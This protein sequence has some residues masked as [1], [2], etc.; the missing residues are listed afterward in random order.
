SWDRASRHFA[1]V[2]GLPGSADLMDQLAVTDDP[3]LLTVILSGGA[4]SEPVPMPENAAAR[5]R[6]TGLS[7][8]PE[9]LGKGTYYAVIKGG[10]VLME[11]R[12][13]SGVVTN[14]FMVRDTRFALRVS[15][16]EPDGGSFM[17]ALYIDQ[18]GYSS[19]DPGLLVV[20]YD[21][22]RMETISAV[23]YAFDGSMTA[24]QLR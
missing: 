24:E 21:T 2:T 20:T 19:I 5:M 15:S 4:V 22:D 6:E 23:R 11:N 16:R 7:D 18:G 1:A 14:E 13:G 9:S 3:D 8:V 17:T 12:T 10:R